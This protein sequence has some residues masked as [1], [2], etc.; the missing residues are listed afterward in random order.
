MQ[1]ISRGFRIHFQVHG[2]GAPVLL[3]HE[4]GGSARS[5]LS[6]VR[7]LSPGFMFLAVDALGHGY[8]DRPHEVQAYDTRDRVA[9]FVAV[10][11]ELDIERV[12][13]WG[14]SMGGRNAW[15]M[16]AHAP[17]R[18]ASL[19]VGGAGPPGPGDDDGPDYLDARAAMLARGDWQGFWK[20]LTP[21]GAEAGPGVQAFRERFERD[22][23]ASALAA[24]S[25][26]LRNWPELPAGIRVPPSCHYS[27]ERDGFL[28]RVRAGAA[29]LGGQLHVIEG[30]GH[31]AH[32]KAEG[33]VAG[34][35]R[36][37]LER[38]SG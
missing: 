13:V 29:Q 34:I 30:V 12:H 35:V 8:S 37:H 11:D 24:V 23:D 17:E 20:V 4:F 14:Y 27:G 6:Y 7:R 33:R 18:I 31:E 10:L 38:W 22:N 16:L 5:W 21:D 28:P 3:L 1:I 26:A 9:D 25:L 19:V 36:D 2:G 32:F 15:A